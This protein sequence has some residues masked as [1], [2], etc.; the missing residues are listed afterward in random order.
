MPYLPQGQIEA[1]RFRSLGRNVKISDRAAIHNPEMISIGD[2][3]RIDDFCVVSG[4]IS[5]GRNV[6][7][8]VH[9][10]IAAGTAGIDFADFSTLAYGVHAFS[11]SD[12]YSGV[13][14]ANPTVPARYKAEIK[15][16]ITVGRHCIVGARSVVFPGVE[17]AEGCAIG[18]MSLVNR[19]TDPWSI[20]RGIPARKTGVRSRQ[21][22]ELEQ[23][24]VS[25]AQCDD[26]S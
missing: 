13:T 3:C 22:L 1:M 23:Q 4:E 24:Y 11:Q 14:M 16:R 2:N 19:S 20:Y 17:L 8:A 15:K 18:A 10:N 9:C 12:D 26:L 5:M 21:L 25:E 6:L 7:F